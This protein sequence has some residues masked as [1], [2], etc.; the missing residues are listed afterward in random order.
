[1]QQEAVPTGGD[2]VEVHVSA[3]ER[4]NA[5]LHSRLERRE[6]DIA[7]AGFG[8]VDRVVVAP[9][10][11]RAI[12]RE[13]FGTSHHMIRCTNRRPLESTHLGKCHGR[14]QAGVF[15]GALHDAAPTGI[16][17]DVQ[18]RAKCPVQ[19]CGPRFLGRHGL[20]SFCHRRIPRRGH[21][22]RY[23]ENRPVAVDHIQGKEQ[24]DLRWA[25]F[26]GDLLERVELLGV[27]EPQHRASPALPDDLRGLRPREERHARNLG[28]LPD[29]FLKAQPPQEAFNTRRDFGLRWYRHCVRFHCLS[30]NFSFS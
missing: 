30:H 3:H 2:V 8:Q 22:Q 12:P 20:G 9:A 18:H 15:A 26:D 13:V 4:P 19:A 29:L 24:R 1:M 14:T 17:G 16:P 25:L 5:S 10:I 28:E 23:G 27:V 21:G 7:Q 11:R 6:V